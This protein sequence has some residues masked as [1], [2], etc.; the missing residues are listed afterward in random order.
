[1]DHVAARVFWDNFNVEVQRVVYRKRA[2]EELL[3]ISK[4]VESA[5][6]TIEVSDP[7]DHYFFR[8]YADGLVGRGN[9]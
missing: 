5:C 7:Q 8:L 2:E 1:M 4:A 9:L 6:D 3:H